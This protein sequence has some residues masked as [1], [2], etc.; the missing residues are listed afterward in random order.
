MYGTHSRRGEPYSYPKTPGMGLLIP[1]TNCFYS[2]LRRLLAWTAF[3]VRPAI[4]QAHRQSSSRERRSMR[5]PANTGRNSDEHVGDES[6]P[7][8]FPVRRPGR[9]RPLLSWVRRPDKPKQFLG[10]S[11]IDQLLFVVR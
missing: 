3:S 6:G 2:G 5:L 7:C 4:R 9:P 11:L 10:V 8:T 1:I